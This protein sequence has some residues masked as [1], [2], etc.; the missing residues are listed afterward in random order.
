VIVCCKSLNL[1]ELSDLSTENKHGGRYTPL[2]SRPKWAGFLAAVA[3]AR[4]ARG[5]AVSDASSS[6]ATT[7]T[8]IIAGKL[9]PCLV[10]PSVYALNKCR[11]VFSNL[12]IAPPSG[13]SPHSICSSY[14]V[15]RALCR[16]SFQLATVLLTEA[17]HFS[18]FGRSNLRPLR[19]A[20]LGC[21]I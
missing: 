18:S 19:D 1:K 15:K 17:V 20:F 12:F 16:R 5:V 7:G 14:C 11:M 3:R 21:F 9:V 6:A 8:R 10:Q 2:C 4:I 13:P